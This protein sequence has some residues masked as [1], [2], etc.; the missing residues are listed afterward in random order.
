MPECRLS[1][2]VFMMVDIYFYKFLNKNTPGILSKYFL[3]TLSAMKNYAFVIN[4]LYCLYK[5]GIKANGY[6]VLQTI[7]RREREKGGGSGK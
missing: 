2:A 5:Y 3:R 6:Y 1:L 4:P 7:Y